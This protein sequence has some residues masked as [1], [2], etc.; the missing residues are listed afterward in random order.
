MGVGGGEIPAGASSEIWVLGDECGGGG[1]RPP[2][3]FMYKDSAVWG[4]SS[5]PTPPLL[6]CWC[7][8]AL[9]ALPCPPLL[10]HRLFALSDGRSLCFLSLRS[11]SS[12]FSQAFFVLLERSSSPASQTEA[13]SAEPAPTRTPFT[14]KTFKK[15]YK[16]A[17][18]A[19]SSQW[20]I[21]TFLHWCF[22]SA[23]FQKQT[24]VSVLSWPLEASSAPPRVWHSI[25]VPAVL[26]YKLLRYRQ[27][28]LVRFRFFII[29]IA[30]SSSPPAAVC[31]CRAG[32][33]SCFLP[34]EGR[35]RP[36]SSPQ[37]I[38]QAAFS[39]SQ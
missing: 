5:P 17:V 28:T 9:L 32:I 19:H 36:P 26:I 39:V 4:S 7:V 20:M 38:A 15:H 18:H 3:R 31:C 6:R 14:S 16:S 1:E 30:A 34:A 12:E 27:D 22:E 13:D 33:S 29:T 11:R 37:F 21:I 10:Q 35:S 8:L 25:L 24:A 23:W 2:P